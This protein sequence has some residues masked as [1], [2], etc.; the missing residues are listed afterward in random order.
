MR[1]A[2]SEKQVPEF[3]F[4]D[5]PVSIH[6]G[7]QRA[8]LRDLSRQETPSEARPARFLA[9]LRGASAIESLESPSIE[10]RTC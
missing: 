10:A 5:G 7:P 8:E 2:S 4:I 6:F 1:Y 9:M 3:C